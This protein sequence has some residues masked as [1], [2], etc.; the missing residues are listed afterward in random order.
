LSFEA[1][2]LIEKDHSVRP[3]FKQ[4]IRRVNAI[5]H[6]HLQSKIQ[7]SFEDRG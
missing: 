4:V 3:S 7:E 2:S 6:P 5:V 1:L